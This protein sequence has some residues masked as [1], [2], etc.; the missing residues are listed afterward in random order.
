MAG[1]LG[2]VLGSG[3]RG[4]ELPSGEWRVLERHGQ[5]EYRLPHQIDDEANLRQLLDAGCD[6]V[7]AI[8]SV[9]GLHEELVPGTLLCPD[10]FIA[11]TAPPATALVGMSAHRAHGFD[12]DWRERVCAALPAD[13]QSLR[14][15]GVY[16]QATG[17][18]FE[19]PAEVRLIAVHADVVGMTIGSEC[20][21][22]GELGLRY[23][24]LCVVDNLANGIGK[25]VPTLAEIQATRVA[26]RE[27]LRRVLTHALPHL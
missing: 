20:V 6:R 23:A 9:G 4:L 18:R 19:T 8:S 5:H 1:R 17:P 12:P 13:G 3:A 22:A 2:L 15:R 14:D 16:W 11:L 7:L 26:N 25:R 10:D 27:L 24:A 21:V